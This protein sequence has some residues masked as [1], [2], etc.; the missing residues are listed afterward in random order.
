MTESFLEHQ[1]GQM[2][3]VGFEGLMPPGYILDWI[4]EGHIGGLI[5]FGR[6]VESPGQLARLTQ[7]CHEAARKANRPPLL[8]GIDQE[9]GTVARLREGFSES[10]GALALGAANDP[11]LAEE[12][13]AMLARE[14]RALGINWNYAPVVDLTHDIA[15]PTVGTR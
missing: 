11:Q 3:L 7:T 6:N 2:L 1:L 8:I 9:G 4:A 15:N 13:S 10:P 5:L 12:V 14:M